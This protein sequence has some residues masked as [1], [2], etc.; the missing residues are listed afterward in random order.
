MNY[1]TFEAADS[2][3]GMEGGKRGAGVGSRRRR[4]IKIADFVCFSEKVN[5]L[6][7]KAIRILTMTAPI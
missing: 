1:L 7:T 5:S 4:V 6:L 3:E 2:Y